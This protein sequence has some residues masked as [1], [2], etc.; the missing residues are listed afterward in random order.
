MLAQGAVMAIE[1][2]VILGRCFDKYRDVAT[3]L[4]RYQDARIEVTTRK[5]IGANDNAVRFHNPALATEAGATAYVD[6][7]WSRD[8]IIRRYEWIFTYDVTAA[9]I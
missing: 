5:V 6:R 8:A 1:D 2:A 7:E 9:A 4:V 3:A